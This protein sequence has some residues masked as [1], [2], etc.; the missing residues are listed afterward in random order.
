MRAWICSRML[1]FLELPRWHKGRLW[2]ADMF[3][4]QVIAFAADV[5]AHVVIT[6]PEVLA[7]FGWIP[8]GSLLAVTLGGGCYRDTL[9]DVQVSADGNRLL[10]TAGQ[11]GMKP[12]PSGQPGLVAQPAWRAPPSAP[13][14]DQTCPRTSICSP[15]RS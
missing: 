7:G 3:A 12:G 6:V 14:A 2:A 1:S 11:R 5:A 15:G 9:A 13:S 10:V 8:D 4:G